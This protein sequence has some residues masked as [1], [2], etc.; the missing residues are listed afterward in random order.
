VNRKPPTIQRSLVGYL[1]ALILGAVLVVG[2]L[3]KVVDPQAF[4]EQIRVE[5]LDFALPSD[6]VALIGLG[7]ELGLGTALILGTR[8]LWILIPA[9]TL[10]VFFLVLTGMSYWKFAHGI[11]DES[12]SCGCFGNLVDRTPAEAFWQD[13]LLMVPAL[14]VAFLGRPRTAFPV[15]R[16][17]LTAAVTLGSVSFAWKAPELPLDDLATRLK[18]GKLAQEICSGSEENRL[19]LT[20]LI[21]GLEEGN[22]IVILADLSSPEFGA[23]VEELNEYFSS[24]H[25]PTLW[26]LSSSSPEEHRRFF[27]QWGPA[28]KILEAPRPLLRP[29]Y[30]SLP[31]SFLLSNGTVI[32][33]FSGLAPM[34]SLAEV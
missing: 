1:G 29:L 4:A 13:L 12:T 8:R 15:N 24:G 25:G 28:F 5:G 10:V 31:R 19:C 21:P 32:R 16:V 18:P 34:E 14:L 3:T 9:G 22:H 7:L 33:T 17:A 23:A 6:V 20:G 2:G 11:V 26:V 27:W 30:R